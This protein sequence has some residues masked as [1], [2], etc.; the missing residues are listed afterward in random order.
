MAMLCIVDRQTNR[1][2]FL[3]RLE[4]YIRS[5][6]S[7]GHQ[8]AI[9]LLDLE[10][11]KNINDSL[12]RTA[13]DVLLKQVAEW[14]T[15][16]TGD[17]NLLARIDADHFAIVLPEVKSEGNLAQ[18]VDN[19]LVA[20]LE[21]PFHL[22][23]TVLRIGVKVGVA[24]FPDDGDDADILF[25]NAEAALKMAKKSGDRCL[26]HTQ[27]MTEA[28]AGKLILE[29]QLRQAIDN[30]EFVLYYQPKVNLA[31]GKVTCAESP[32]VCLWKTSITVSPACRQSAPWV[33][34]STISAL[35]SPRSATWPNCL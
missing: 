4:P 24:L 5:A 35:D 13:G 20:F 7:G 29:N 11:F 25:M 3:E 23:D 16:S 34:L 18:L 6:A 31:S 21:H 33:S 32:R 19:M 17:A 2:L 9:G 8:L 22:N 26:F 15:N 14:L 28:V 27:E 10:R 30:E 12:G 1:S